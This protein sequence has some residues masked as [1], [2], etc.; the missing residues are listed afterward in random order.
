MRTGLA[1]DTCPMLRPLS[2]PLNT[3]VL[4]SLFRASEVGGDLGHLLV[5]QTGDLSGADLC[6]MPTVQL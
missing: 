2:S 5:A 3:G 4:F 6:S 1:I